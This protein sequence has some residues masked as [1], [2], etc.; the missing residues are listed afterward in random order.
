[1]AAKYHNLMAALDELHAANRDYLRRLPAEAGH[2]AELAAATDRADLAN[3]AWMD[4]GEV[5]T[6][7]HRVALVERLN[8]IGKLM[9]ASQAILRYLIVSQ[10]APGN[11]GPPVT[12]WR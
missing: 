3:V 2:S 6:D 5:I 12:A 1:M 8:D 11:S 7:E 9:K 4:S 10:A